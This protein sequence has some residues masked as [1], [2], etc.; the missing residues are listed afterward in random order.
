MYN[1]QA[2]KGTLRRYSSTWVINRRKGIPVRT[3]IRTMTRCERVCKRP[4]EVKLERAD[5]KGW[6]PVKSRQ[7]SSSEGT[8][9]ESGDLE[10]PV[11]PE[12]EEGRGQEATWL[13]G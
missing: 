9:W 10:R 1:W 12:W 7:F 13:A 4:G 11:Q 8:W 3:E 2:V 6:P 5:M